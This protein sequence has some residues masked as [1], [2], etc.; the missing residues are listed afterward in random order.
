VRNL[1]RE[2]SILFRKAVKQ[3]MTSKKESVEVTGT[4]LSDYLRVRCTAT[5]EVE[6]ND[7]IGGATGLAWIEVGGELPTVEGVMMPS[8]AR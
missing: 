1:D 2:L 7:Q 4:N 6:A 3:L 8:N 5:N